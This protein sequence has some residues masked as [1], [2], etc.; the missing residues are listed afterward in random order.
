MRQDVSLMVICFIF[1]L[2]AGM[3]LIFLIGFL[4]GR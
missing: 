3:L 1:G 2:L 4:I